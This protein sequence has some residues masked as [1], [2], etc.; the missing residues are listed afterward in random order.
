MEGCRKS[1]HQPDILSLKGGGGK[2]GSVLQLSRMTE[3]PSGNRQARCCHRAFWIPTNVITAKTTNPI[4]A[5]IFCLVAE[6]TQRRFACLRGTLARQA[7]EYNLICQQAGYPDFAFPIVSAAR[8]RHCWFTM[9]HGTIHARHYARQSPVVVTWENGIITRAEAGT[10]DP[11]AWIAPAIFDPQVNGYAGGDFQRDNLTREDL[12]RSVDGLQRAGC[13]RFLLT[14]VTDERPRMLAR[15]RHLRELREQSPAL[16]HAIAGWHI[17]GPFLSPEPGFHGAHDPALMEEPGSK[18]MEELRAVVPG[19]P[20][21]VTLAPERHGALEAIHR[22]VQLGI[23]VS[24]GHTDASGETLRTALTAGA[25]GFTHLGNACPSKL[26]RHDNIIVRVLDT[27]GFT[28][29]L[30]P[31]GMHVLAPMFRVLHRALDGESVIYTTDAMSAAGAPPGRYTIGAVELEVGADQVV[32]Q[33]GRPNF[34]GSAL[35]PIEGVFRAAKMLGR[36]WQAVWDGFSTRAA[37]FAGVSAGLEVGKPADFCL[38]EFDTEGKLSLL[39]TIVR[40]EEVC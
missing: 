10:R 12:E 5:L 7:G 16:R 35:R 33:P 22:A 23:R 15:L 2:N 29:S 36:P 19:D 38:M 27:P 26:D 24:L 32:R 4:K 28:V 25:T 11:K 13:A 21:L 40:G 1:Y 39:R 3:V 31:D 6:F 8:I 34:A 30:I 14:L 20:L 18:H 9:S 17:E 37:A